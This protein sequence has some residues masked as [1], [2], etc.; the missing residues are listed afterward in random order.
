MKIE[1]AKLVIFCRKM[2]RPVEVAAKFNKSISWTYNTLNI[3]VM[4][5]YLKKV[6]VKGRTG[7]VC[8]DEDVY[9]KAVSTLGKLELELKFLQ[10]N[11]RVDEDG[12]K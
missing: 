1:E 11:E 7:Y 2:R 10:S 12:K 8:Q 3:M 4:K 5:G 6:K 9:N